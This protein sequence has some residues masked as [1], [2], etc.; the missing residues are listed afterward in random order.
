MGV[1]FFPLEEEERPLNQAFTPLNQKGCIKKAQESNSCLASM[2]CAGTSGS[3]GTLQEMILVGSGE[4]A[5]NNVGKVNKLSVNFMSLRKDV[6]A[7][8][9]CQFEKMSKCSSFISFSKRITVLYH[10]KPSNL[11][12]L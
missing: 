9:I 3:N 11:F 6:S 2:V 5:D 10:K 7:Y 4:M 12:F 8:L 1:G